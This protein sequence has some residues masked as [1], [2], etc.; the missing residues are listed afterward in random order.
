VRLD[1]KVSGSASYAAPHITQVLS[2]ISSSGTSSSITALVGAPALTMIR[3]RRGG[4]SD[5][6]RSA[7]RL[8]QDKLVLVAVFRHET[9]GPGV[10]A[11]VNSHSVTVP[12]EIAR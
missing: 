11:V 2:P 12:S 1:E 6:T 8:A 4:S 7:H 5:L 10:G 3:I 9:L